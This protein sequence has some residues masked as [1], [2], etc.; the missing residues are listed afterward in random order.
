MI[1]MLELL[2]ERQPGN[3]ES[4][5]HDGN[6]SGDAYDAGD[7]GQQRKPPAGAEIT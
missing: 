2:L 6:D 5:N 4:K 7:A 3:Q 1:P